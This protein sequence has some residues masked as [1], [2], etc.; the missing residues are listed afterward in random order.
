M[1][2]ANECN[3]Y[4]VLYLGLWENINNND[5]KGLEFV[6]FENEVGIE[7]LEQLEVSNN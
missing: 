2:K 3:R 1:E 7:K 6:T 4:A 5:F